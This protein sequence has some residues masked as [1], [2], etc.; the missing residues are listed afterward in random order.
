[1]KLIILVFLT[2]MALLSLNG[3][4]GAAVMVVNTDTEKMH[5]Y[6]LSASNQ[7]TLRGLSQRGYR[8]N[9]GDFKY[10]N[11]DEENATV[12]C[13]LMTSVTPS[14][15][16][17]Y[18]K[19][20]EHAF[21]KEFKRA[22]LYDPRTGITIRAD[23]NKLEGGSVYGDAYWLFDITF[24][25]S[26]GERYHLLS[27]YTYESSI[28]ATYACKEMHKTFPLALQKLIHDTVKSPKFMKL[29]QK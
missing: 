9:L 16:E 17:T 4:G 8:V 28:T 15:N 10:V 23:I 2:L 27:K 22:K 21:Q 29:L 13:R 7:T 25:S 3:C 24:I 5:D 12:K 1:M 19:Y 26:N 11:K 18:T 20:I 6:N 14:K